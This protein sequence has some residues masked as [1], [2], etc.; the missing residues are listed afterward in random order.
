MS[1]TIS[2]TVSKNG[3]YSSYDDIDMWAYQSPVGWTLV[4]RDNSTIKSTAKLLASDSVQ[5]IIRRVMELTGKE[6]RFTV[7]D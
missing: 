4:Y 6:M 3:W 1:H 2:F 5:D 7:V